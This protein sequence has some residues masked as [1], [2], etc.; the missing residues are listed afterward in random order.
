VGEIYIYIENV[1]EIRNAYNILAGEPK[2]RFNI[3]V[4][5]ILKIIS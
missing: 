5:I 4:L 1:K 3:D 2:G